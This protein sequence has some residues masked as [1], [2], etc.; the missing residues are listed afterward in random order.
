MTSESK[1]EV[2][3]SK[4]QNRMLPPTQNYLNWG[5]EG[6]KVHSFSAQNGNYV[7]SPSACR[8]PVKGDTLTFSRDTRQ[9]FPSVSKLFWLLRGG[10][11]SPVDPVTQF[12]SHL[13]YNHITDGLVKPQAEIFDKRT[14]WSGPSHM[15]RCRNRS[16]SVQQEQPTLSP[17]NTH[18]SV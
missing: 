8:S 16:P 3:N 7:K 1:S 6:E 13:C 17:P 9:W 15:E 11:L 5:R 10:L 14:I 18:S 4:M 12:D 2:R